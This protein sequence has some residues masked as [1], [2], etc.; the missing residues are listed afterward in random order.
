M[1]SK[2]RS[3]LQNS[4]KHD[5]CSGQGCN[6]RCCSLTG[7]QQAHRLFPTIGFITLSVGWYTRA[8]R[9]AHRAKPPA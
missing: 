9:P 7:G 6:I 8:S 4:E 3:I 1:L 5:R 2:A